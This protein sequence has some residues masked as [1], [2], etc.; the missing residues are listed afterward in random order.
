MN[1]EYNKRS[2]AALLFVVLICGEEE[3][4]GWL[5][6]VRVV[7]DAVRINIVTDF[8]GTDGRTFIT[9]TDAM[10]TSRATF[11]GGH[12]GYCILD[13]DI[14]AGVGKTATTYASTA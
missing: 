5:V 1:L 14:A 12:L 4:V 11:L 8:D 7:A 6:G 2:A 9:F 3:L 13:G 10:Q